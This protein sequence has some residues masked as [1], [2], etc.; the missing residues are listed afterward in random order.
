MV[1]DEIDRLGGVSPFGTAC[2]SILFSEAPE[3][4]RPK[5]LS[6]IQ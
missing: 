2:C 4:V 1:G 3:R 5:S 6:P